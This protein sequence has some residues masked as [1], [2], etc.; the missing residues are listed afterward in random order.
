M[1]YGVAAP[2]E[3][4]DVSDVPDAWPRTGNP[5]LLYAGRI[6]LQKNVHL[7]VEMVADLMGRGVDVELAV[8]GERDSAGFPELGWSNEGY[9]DYL[10]D[11]AKRRDVTDRIHFLG[12]LPAEAMAA[13]YRA[14]ALN[15]TLST[16]RTEDFGFVPV[17]AAYCGLPTVATAW[18]GFHDT[19]WDGRTGH[20]V[21]VVVAEHG[22]RV[23]WRAGAD[24]VAG[25]LADDA[26]RERLGGMASVISQGV[27]HPDDF[28]V[29]LRRVV[30]DAARHR[31]GDARPLTIAD[32]VDDATVRFLQTVQRDGN[33]ARRD[34]FFAD[35]RIARYFGAYTTGSSPRFRPDDV[36]YVP[37]DGELNDDGFVVNDP[38]WPATIAL[39]PQERVLLAHVDGV[40]TVAEM[41]E[42]M[43]QEP[44]EVVRRCNDLQDKGALL[45]AAH[46]SEQPM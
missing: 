14:A 17:E 24:H 10:A 21:P 7:L 38:C 26:A 6:N 33:D 28:A 1:P 37:V 20:L 43:N 25:L 11:L 19:V 41:A 36:A 35:D 8:V 32:M 34:A 16:F 39:S 27:Y 31:G 42:D 30:V 22:F 4:I 23:D 3:S 12:A 29:R 45:P 9:P 5:V 40:R 44:A 13:C 2:V 18:G 15:V 46:G